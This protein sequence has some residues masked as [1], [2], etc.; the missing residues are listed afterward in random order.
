M[1]LTRFLDVQASDIYAFAIIAWHLLS[2]GDQFFDKTDGELYMQLV[3]LDKRP[4]LPP[5]TNADLKE[6]INACWD[7]TPSKRPSI[8]G[9]VSWLETLV[10]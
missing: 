5:D 9:V 6:L 2:H 10:C 7:S 1:C 4:N 8:G 3:D